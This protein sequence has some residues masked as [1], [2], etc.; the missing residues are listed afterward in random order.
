MKI[1]P[2]FHISLLE[3]HK[4]SNIPT[5]IQPPPPPVVVEPESEWYEVQE[6]LDSKIL[7]NR[8]YYLVKWKGFSVEYNS[9]YLSTDINSSRLIMTFYKYYPSK[10]RSNIKSSNIHPHR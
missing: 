7:R 5:R 9:W 6:I 4:E 2:V 1:H 8:L 3:L 10:S